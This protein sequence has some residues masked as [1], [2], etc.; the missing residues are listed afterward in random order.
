MALGTGSGCINHPGVTAKGRCKQCGRPFCSACEVSGS[1]GRFCSDACKQKFEAFVE[2]VQA[3]E[4]RRTGMSVGMKLK[5]ILGTA[6]GKLIAL[7]IVIGFVCAV[8]YFMEIP[9]LSPLVHRF[10]P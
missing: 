10:V 1:T 2:R 5:R 9:G 4:G 8:A 6:I 7:L 3:L